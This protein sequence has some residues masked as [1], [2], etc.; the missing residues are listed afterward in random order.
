[1]EGSNYVYSTSE[2]L[3]SLL[4]YIKLHAISDPPPPFLDYFNF[5]TFADSLTQTLYL[6]MV[7]ELFNS[8][9]QYEK[10]HKSVTLM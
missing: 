8:L 7:Y 4:N 9:V 10:Y 2:T 5:D 1:M 6:V 3:I